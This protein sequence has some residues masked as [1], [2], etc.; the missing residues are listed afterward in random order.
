VVPEE[1]LEPSQGYPYRILS[2]ARLPFHHSGTAYFSITYSA[3]FFN[4]VRLQINFKAILKSRR[5]LLRLALCAVGSSNRFSL[6]ASTSC[7]SVKL[8]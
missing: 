2:P 4:S 1:G 5:G 7:S 8:M 3:F 6:N